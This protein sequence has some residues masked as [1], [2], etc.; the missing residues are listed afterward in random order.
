[1]IQCYNNK[2][3]NSYCDS[4]RYCCDISN[5]TNTFYWVV[6]VGEICYM[7]IDPVVILF[8]KKERGT[9]GFHALLKLLLQLFCYDTSAVD[10][11]YTRFGDFPGLAA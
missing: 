10:D 5:R 6:I 4:F 3:F 1:M 11:V 7:D 8:S 2:S 9:L